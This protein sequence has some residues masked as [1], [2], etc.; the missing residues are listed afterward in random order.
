MTYV[1]I[2]SLA[3]SIFSLAEC[4]LVPNPGDSNPSEVTTNLDKEKAKGN[5]NS[6]YAYT[7]NGIVV[8][9]HRETKKLFV[10]NFL[11]ILSQ[12]LFCC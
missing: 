7:P 4:Q 10:L 11:F 9:V 1:H 3:I 12:Q 6:T 5:N 8:F 2:Y